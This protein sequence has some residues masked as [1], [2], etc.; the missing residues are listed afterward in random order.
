MTSGR[1]SADSPADV[2]SDVTAS[3]AS[4]AYTINDTGGEN[5]KS[6]SRVTESLVPDLLRGETG[7]SLD[8]LDLPV[9]ALLTEADRLT[10][11]RQTRRA[12]DRI[13]RVRR[14]AL[15]ACGHLPFVERPAQFLSHLRRFISDPPTR[16]DLP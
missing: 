14:V 6:M 8:T 13:P 12:L 10:N 3:G 2:S 9:L 16:P 15:P 5:L 7:R 4:L 11:T 1:A